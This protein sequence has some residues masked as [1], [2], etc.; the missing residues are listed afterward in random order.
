MMKKYISEKT[1]CSLI[2]RNGEVLIS[3]SWME[4]QLLSKLGLKNLILGKFKRSKN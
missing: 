4:K 1:D 3:K 2:F